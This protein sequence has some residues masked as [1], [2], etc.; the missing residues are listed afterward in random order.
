MEFD[1]DVRIDAVVMFKAAVQRTPLGYR[2]ET[3]TLKAAVA[4]SAIC[5]LHQY[6]GFTQCSMLFG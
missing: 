5:H 2:A 4:E 6:A 3:P 1:D